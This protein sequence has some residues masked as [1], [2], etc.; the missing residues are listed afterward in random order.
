VTRGEE[1]VFVLRMCIAQ[2]IRLGRVI[3]KI[4][5]THSPAFQIDRRIWIDSLLCFLHVLYLP[6]RIGLVRFSQHWGR[7]LGTDTL[8]TSS[9]TLF[10]KAKSHAE[11]CGLSHGL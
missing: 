10:V 3:A 1:M 4:P 7:L 6:E 5:F 11:N 8:C 9:G 2:L